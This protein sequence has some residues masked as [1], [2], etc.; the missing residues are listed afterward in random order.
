[1]CAMVVSG[2]ILAFSSLSDEK[3]KVSVV[4]HENGEVTIL[5]TVFDVSSG[6]SVEKYLKDNGFDPQKTEIVNTESFEGKYIAEFKNESSLEDGAQAISIDVD[7]EENNGERV[8][9]KKLVDKE[10]NVSIE[11]KVNGEVVELTE[12]EK[13][14]LSNKEEKTILR[15]KNS[16]KKE[17]SPQE[18]EII[19]ILDGDEKTYEIKI[20]GGEFEFKGDGKNVMVIEE[21]LDEN[22]ASNVKTRVRTTEGKILKEVDVNWTEDEEDGKK[23]FI[24]KD[25]E[26]EEIEV[27][28]FIDRED[29][30]DS[31]VLQ[32]NV[33]E[34]KG[35]DGF[36]EDV[37]VVKHHSTVNTLRSEP[38]F[39]H[40]DEEMEPYT[41][42]IV[43]KL[44][45]PKNESRNEPQSEPKLNTFTSD[46]AKLPIEELKFFPNPTDGNFRMSF[47]L[48]QRGQTAIT[49]YDANGKEVLKKDLG[50]FQ[51]NWDNNIDL[52][53]F[54][55][56]T[57]IL[58]I[59]QNNLRLAEKIIVN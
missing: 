12:A 36:V 1:M 18:V 31:E 50:N 10:G 51:G 28:V 13:E 27:Q 4:H 46:N 41:V 42:A 43:S 52:T 26:G 30:K 15:S 17:G 45:E 19:E 21:I 29:M 34:F 7:V 23:V 56:G 9:I 55:S 5:D 3:I 57:Y 33:M 22:G 59:T 40:E 14:E 54:E 24:T 58:N 32:E 47:F 8:E 16:S 11:K 35:P 25:P 2:L 38:L 6:Y 20:E 37:I 49:I 48:P 44:K 39:M 53:S